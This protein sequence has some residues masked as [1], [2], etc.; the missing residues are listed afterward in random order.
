MKMLVAIACAAFAVAASG[1]DYPAPRIADYPA[2]VYGY[3]APQPRY[4]A[5]QMG[6]YPLPPRARPGGGTG[7][8]Y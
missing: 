8:L 6:Q 7:G 1:A 4:P 5:P 2:S 3:V